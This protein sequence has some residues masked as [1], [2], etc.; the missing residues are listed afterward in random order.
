MSRCQEKAPI[1]RNARLQGS[2]HRVDL[3][4]PGVAPQVQPGQFVHVHLPG[5]EHRVLRRPFSVF[6]VE[7]AAGT[8]SIVY[9]VVGEGTAHLA[10][11]AA[12]TCLDLMGPL[13]QGYS[14][15]PDGVT[16]VVV[17]GGYGCAATYLFARRC[18]DKAVVCLGG[19]SADDLLLVED[20]LALGADVRLATDDGSRGHRGVVTDLLEAALDATPR[21][22][23]I[24]CGPNPMLKAVCRIVAARGL[25]A[26]V[27]LDHAMCCG[28]GACFACVIKKRSAEQPAGWEYVRTCLAGPVFRASE[29]VWD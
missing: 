8:L 14:T 21:P 29:V 18:R 15:P 23:V 5:F 17:A 19:R 4:A 13:G 2:Y 1:L 9:K 27:S 24:A 7:P 25:E 16:P 10:G 6:N 28:V 22:W 3:Q 20:F 12:G 11:L 26:E